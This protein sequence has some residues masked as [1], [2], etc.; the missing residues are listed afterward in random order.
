M[1]VTSP[2][3]SAHSSSSSSTFSTYL[4]PSNI[5]SSPTLLRLLPAASAYLGLL[6]AASASGPTASAPLRRLA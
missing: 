2:R 6:P 1:T 3:R 5:T 4:G